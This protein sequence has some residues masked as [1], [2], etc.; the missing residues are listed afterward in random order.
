MQ[1]H[2]LGPLITVGSWIAG[3]S[4]PYNVYATMTKTWLKATLP[5]DQNNLE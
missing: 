1:T 4:I 5:E 2:V 3:R